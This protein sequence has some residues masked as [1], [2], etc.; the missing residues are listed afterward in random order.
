MMPYRRSTIRKMPPRTR[1]IARMLNELESVHTRMRNL[2][3]IIELDERQRLAEAKRL[4]ALEK[5][6]L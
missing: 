3:P 5:G 2:L 1:L 6:E 4:A